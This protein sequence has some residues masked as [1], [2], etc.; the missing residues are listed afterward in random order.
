MEKIQELLKCTPLNSKKFIFGLVC[1]ICWF[2]LIAF[3]V[4]KGQDSSFLTAMV[5]SA[6][7][8]QGL[9]LGGQAFVDA[10]VRKAFAA[11]PVQIG[12]S[13]EE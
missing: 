11:A 8:V 4:A 3:G 5:Y 10:L 13:E 12:H 9:Y 2:G 1:T 6:G 7:I